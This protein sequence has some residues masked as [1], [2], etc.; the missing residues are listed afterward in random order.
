MSFTKHHP[1]PEL[2][3]GTIFIGVHRYLIIPFQIN[4]AR[5]LHGQ[6]I[7]N[8]LAI[9]LFFIWFPLISYNGS[10]SRHPRFLRCPLVTGSFDTFITR[11]PDA[12]LTLL[13]LHLGYGASGNILLGDVTHGNNKIILSMF[14][15]IFQIIL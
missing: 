8:P 15:C 13:R 14:I 3:I 1:R 11:T 5:I 7:C 2:I 10:C 6:R 4:T 9:F 12:S